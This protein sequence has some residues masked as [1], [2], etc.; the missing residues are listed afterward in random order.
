MDVTMYSL[1]QCQSSS[2]SV[3][4]RVILLYN[5]I[6]GMKRVGVYNSLSYLI[7][8]SLSE[9]HTSRTTLYTCGV[10]FLA[11][12]LACLVTCG[13]I[14]LKWV[15]LD[16]SR[17]LSELP[18]IVSCPAPCQWRATARVQHL[19]ERN[20][21]QRQCNAHMATADNGRQ[22]QPTHKQYKLHTVVE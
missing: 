6:V 18:R 7:G 3:A 14:N 9:P 16:I 5:I 13:H 19:H 11:G 17:R 22:G 4:K 12:F 21:E 1:L 10:C 20:L 15:H 2:G 8:A